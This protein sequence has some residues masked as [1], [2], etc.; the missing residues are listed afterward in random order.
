MN[1]AIFLQPTGIDPAITNLVA[2]QIQNGGQLSFN[3]AWDVGLMTNGRSSGGL[4]YNIQTTSS[5]TQAIS[6]GLNSQNVAFT[7][8]G[9][10]TTGVTQ[11][12]SYTL[13][14]SISATPFKTGGSS[15]WCA[16][17]I[18]TWSLTGSNG[19]SAS[20]TRLV[21]RIWAR[22]PNTLMSPSAT[23]L[24]DSPNADLYNIY[25]QDI[26]MNFNLWLR[27]FY[28]DSDIRYIPTSVTLGP[29]IIVHVYS[30]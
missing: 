30:N 19:E 16:A 28:I 5:G 1:P 15:N 6:F 23:V 2:N 4:N 8:N 3:Y 7:Y 18:F 26:D 10:A 29:L 11:N 20:G 17:I 13:N 21:G 14:Y 27:R 22:F 12:V 25:Y 24:P 9:Q